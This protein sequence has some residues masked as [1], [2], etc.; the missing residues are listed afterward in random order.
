VDDVLIV[1]QW[2]DQGPT[3][4][5]ATKTLTAG[6][7]TIKM[8]YYENAG[9][10]V[11]KLSWSQNG[12]STGPLLFTD[13]VILDN[14][15]YSPGSAVNLTSTIRATHDISNELLDTEIYNTA[16]TKI[17]Q[18]ST[19]ANLIA[20][21]D[22]NSPWNF[23]APAL[24]NYVVKLGLFQNDWSKLYYWDSTANTF[25]VSQTTPTPP[26]T[27]SSCPS[28][29]TNAFT[30]CYYN[31][32]TL[33]NLVL[34]R[35]DPAINFDWGAGS[36]DPSIPNDHFSARWQG[37]FSFNPATYTF[38]AT[39][40]DGVRVWVDNTLVIDKW[41]DQPATTYTASLPLGGGTHL[42]KVEYYENGGNAVAK[43]SWSQNV[44]T[45]P[46]PDTTPPSISITAPA[47]G[48]TVSGNTSIT[49][50]A[51]DN[52]GVSSVQ[53][54]IDGN[55][56]GPQILNTPYTLNWDTTAFVNGSHAITGLAMDTAGNQTLSTPISVMV[57]NAAP[58][59]PP[60]GG[61]AF[62]VSVSMPNS[63]FNPG[64]NTTVTTNV[65]SANSLSNVNIDTEIYDSSNAKVRQDVKNVNLASGQLYSSN[66]NV[67]LPAASGVYIVKV[68][69][70]SQ[71]WS[72]NYF[73]KNNAYQFTVGSPPPSPTPGQTYN[74]NIIVPQNNSTV[75]GLVEIKAN[76]SGLDVN[77][78]NIGWR[79]GNGNFISL[80]TDP[81]QLNLKHAWID[82]SN[83][84]WN[85]SNAYP[86]EFQGTDTNNNVI[87]HSQINI[88]VVH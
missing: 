44:G 39:A 34:T 82:F 67:T 25:T 14:T 75:S 51:S 52:A 20:N 33:S 73:W 2:K 10:A 38:S 59:P 47:N 84:N 3:T 74:L 53:F 6:N 43:V 88:T 5:T 85:P 57:S 27:S 54:K 49:A 63:N 40:D 58:P 15:S 4:Y 61:G 29:G 31:D 11:A 72:Q 26:P 7:H 86:L 62:A 78:Y 87:G 12:G 60:P 35:T 36:P 66:W 28:A 45:T 50:G 32:Q 19:P 21:Q 1:D 69:V 80:D 8:E 83:W 76:I 37:N 70:F 42:V 18:K 13:K 9:G 65:T 79:T 68:G 77:S 41:L 23:N 46:P 55:N 56:I 22:F 16:G 64:A 71:D 24:G 48:S 30:G 81:A 17:L